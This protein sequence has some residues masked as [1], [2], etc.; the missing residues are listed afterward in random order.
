M[1]IIEKLGGIAVELR[2]NPH[3]G[4]IAWVGHRISG[5]ILLLYLALHLWGLGSATGGKAAF[6]T[7][8]QTFSGPVFELLEALVVAIAAFHMFNGLRI[9]AVDFL[10]LTRHQK[11]MF[12]GVLGCF[13]LVLA[14]TG[15][16]FF[17]RAFG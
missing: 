15:W 16:V 3:S 2:L 5:L 7:Q 8:M 10:G 14:G 9:I 11:A 13:A 6:D 17:A 12:A 4:S 1:M